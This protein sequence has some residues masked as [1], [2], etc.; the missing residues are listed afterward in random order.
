MQDRMVN[1]ILR[2]P[3]IY[4]VQGANLQPYNNAQ[5]EPSINNI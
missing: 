4:T 1:N 2:D 3:S 5:G